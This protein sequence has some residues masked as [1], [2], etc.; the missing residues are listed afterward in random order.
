M[1]EVL[2]GMTHEEDRLHQRRRERI[3]R[4]KRI[5]RW[6]P[7]RSNVHRYPVL[8]WFTNAARKRSYLWSFRV[9]AAVP[10][11]YAGAILALLPLYGIQLPA[12]VG[13]AFLFRANLPILFSLQFITNPLTVLPAYFTSYQVGKVVLNLFG[14]SSPNVNMAEMRAFLETINAGDLGVNLKYLATLWSITCL[15]SLI[16]GVFLATIAAAIYKFAAYEV[17][18]S[19]KRLKSFNTRRHEAAAR[20]RA[21]QATEPPLHGRPSPHE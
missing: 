9:R 2:P 10:A 15:G 11:L 19:V 21:A 4:V 6:M 12:A 20:S 13:L 16:L 14:V 17:D 18:L 5:L 1:I 8:R 3:A 7:R